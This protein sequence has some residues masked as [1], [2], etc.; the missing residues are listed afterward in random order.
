MR[1]IYENQN[2]NAHQFQ[3]DC[4]QNDLPFAFLQFYRHNFPNILAGI[5]GFRKRVKNQ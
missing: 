3:K 1:H 5:F 2:A 4:H